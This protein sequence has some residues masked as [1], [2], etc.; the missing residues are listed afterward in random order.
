[1]LGQIE[2][3][4]EAGKEFYQKALILQSPHAKSRAVRLLNTLE[5][6][7]YGNE[8]SVQDFRRELEPIPPE[9]KQDP[10]I[11]DYNP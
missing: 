4:V 5:T 11:Y 8:Q 9:L 3:C 1:M 2:Q 7:G 10:L 6:V